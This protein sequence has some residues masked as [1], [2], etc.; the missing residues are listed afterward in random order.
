MVFCIAINLLGIDFAVISMILWLIAELTR[1]RS[2]R[3]LG[4]VCRWMMPEAVPIV[5]GESPELR[6][7]L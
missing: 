4:L 5:P 1:P 2:L 3:D 7:A 6:L